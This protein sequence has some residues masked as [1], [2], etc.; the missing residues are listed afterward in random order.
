MISDMKR[1]TIRQHNDFFTPRDCI[2]G[3]SDYFTVKTKTA[4]Y[5]NDPRYGIVV[6][7]RYFKLAVD[8]N[9][10]KRVLRDWIANNEH[11]MVKDLDYIIIANK[12][13]CTVTR[14]EGRDLMAKVFKK[15]AKVYELQ[16]EQK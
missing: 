10:A 13:I 11:L 14:D 7:K 9:R 1:K 12:E 6:T 5:V 8:R 2:S 16:N 4:K 3:R 15:I